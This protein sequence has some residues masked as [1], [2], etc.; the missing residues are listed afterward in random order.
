MNAQKIH[1]DPYERGW[2]IFSIILIALFAAAVSFAAFGLGIQV[3]AP[4][5]RVD[6]NTV[7]KDP[8]SPWSNPGLREV[9]PGKYD[10]YILAHAKPQWEYLPKEITIPVGSKVTF[11]V[12]SSDVQH[13]FKIQN[14]NANFQVVPGQVS[15]LTIEFKIAGTYNFICTEYCGVGHAV[16]Y[17]AVIVTPK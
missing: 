13:G 3:P 14:T 9:S 10:A 15:K 12:T 8:N 7:A 6:P 16:M 4:Y 2:I 1:V 5:E 11:Y 17:G